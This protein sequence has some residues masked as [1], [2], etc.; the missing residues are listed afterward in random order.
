MDQMF[1]TE[2]TRGKHVDIYSLARAFE[3]DCDC[4]RNHPWFDKLGYMK[5]INTVSQTITGVKR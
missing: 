4:I 3:R 5:S 2:I 1:L